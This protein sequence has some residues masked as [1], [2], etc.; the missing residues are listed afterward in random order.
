[1]PP[2]QRTPESQAESRTKLRTGKLAPRLLR[3]LVL[4]RLGVRQPE[5]LVHAA[6]GEDAAAIGVGQEA[7]VLTADPITGATRH[8]GWYAVHIACN[9]VAAMGARPIGVLATILLPETADEAD[10]EAVT[11]DVDRACRELSIEV[12]GGHT[13]VV[14]GLDSALIVMTAVGRAARD[15]LLACAE[16]RAG[17]DLVLTKAAG[18]EGSAILATDLEPHLR[19]RLPKDVVARAQGFI[20]EISVVKDGLLAADLGAVALHDP[21]E[22]GVLGAVWELAEAARCGYEIEA[23][24]VPVRAET[25]AICGLFEADPL[26]LISSGALLAAAPDGQALVDR[27]QAGGIE[28]ALIGRLTRGPDRWL[29]EASGRHPAGPVEQDE[30]WRIM[31]ALG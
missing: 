2:P 4:G 13:E 11:G 12:L 29:M 8:A 1:V 5:V 27:L 15:R 18:L 19:E 10:V 6:F 17:H 24:A 3:R 9:D 26:K 16:A 31:E 25:R 14:A 30:L 21:T 22:G 7:V 20:A 28:A 23:T